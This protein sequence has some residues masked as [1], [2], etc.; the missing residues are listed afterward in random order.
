MD[1]SSE[2]VVKLPSNPAKVTA[3]IFAHDELTRL[4]E[5]AKEYPISKW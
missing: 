2:T 1:I 4:I 3:G 5:A